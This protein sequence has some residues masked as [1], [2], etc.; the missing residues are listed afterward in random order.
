MFCLSLML[1]KT[2]SFFLLWLLLV[3]MHPLSKLGTLLHL[4]LCT[5]FFLFSASHLAKVSFFLH[6]GYLS[7]VDFDCGIKLRMWSSLFSS[8]VNAECR[9]TDKPCLIEMSG[10]TWSTNQKC[11]DKL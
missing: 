10:S 4:T 7:V 2:E 9:Y 3:S 1:S 11:S 5:H 8:A 6:L